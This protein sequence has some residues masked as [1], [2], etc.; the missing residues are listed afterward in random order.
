MALASCIPGGDARNAQPFLGRVR[1]SPLEESAQG[2]GHQILL[3]MVSTMVTI[4][5][6]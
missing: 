6:P 4:T 1:R 5:Q 3:E 2:S